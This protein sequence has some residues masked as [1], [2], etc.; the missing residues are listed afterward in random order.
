MLSSVSLI[1]QAAATS[2]RRSAR[3]PVAFKLFTSSYSTGADTASAAKTDEKQYTELVRDFLDP[4]EFYGAIKRN[5]IDFFTGVPDSLLKD[6][7]AYVTS[8]TPSNK[9]VITANEGNAIALAAGH[10]FA[11]GKSACVYLQNSGLGNIINPLMSLAAP[12][13]YSVPMLMLIGWRGEPGKKDEP[14]HLVQGQA[15]PALLAS[16]NIPF[17]VLP[18]FQE[19]A[20]KVLRT[21]AEYMEQNQGPYAILV[22]RQTF[23]PYKLPAEEPKFELNREG[24]LKLVVDSLGQRDVVVGTTGMLSREL[25]EY[26]VARK[27]GHE[28]D[29]LTVGSMGHASSIALGIALEKPN[30]KVYCLDG[31]GAMLMHMGA[32][33]TVAHLEQENFKHVLI[34]N[35]AH[36]SVGGQPTNA[37]TDTFSFT[38]IA[39]GMGYK[40][41]ETASS[42]EEI[43]EKLAA[44]QS[45]EGP[46]M[47]EIF[48][49][50]GGRKDLGR[51]T[52][53][54]IQN[55]EDFMTFLADDN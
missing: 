42:T 49:N 14:Q 9:H 39:E 17:Q 7:C 16:L 29:F 26:R 54:P 10:H 19:G 38:K 45:A 3:N 8:N 23:V 12:E 1:R 13:V 30:R 41:T 6:F 46:A 55:K 44:L 18:D 37:L 36:D 47:L 22:R 35:G 48:V 27:D 2:V 20:E 53:T 4:A 21:A 5:N 32:S 51:P 25:F 24:A 33:A 34:N 15:T 31:D 43:K 52:R 40:W 50:R 28:K 11:T